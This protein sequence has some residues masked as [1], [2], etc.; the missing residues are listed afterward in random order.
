MRWIHGLHLPIR[1][2]FGMDLLIWTTGYIGT[3]VISNTI[4]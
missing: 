3:L 1:G 2:P 4:H